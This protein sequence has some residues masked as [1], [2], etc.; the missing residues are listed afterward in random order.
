MGQS[1][2]QAQRYQVQEQNCKN[3]D[4]NTK[5]SG[6]RAPRQ[7]LLWS[8]SFLSPLASVVWAMHSGEAGVS[9]AAQCWE[10]DLRSSR[11]QG[12]QAPG[13]AY[14]QQEELKVDGSFIKAKF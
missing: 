8:G 1:H 7:M 11:L 13:M 10:K 9:G 2:H 4:T 12:I 14:G 5:Q 3:T 6:G